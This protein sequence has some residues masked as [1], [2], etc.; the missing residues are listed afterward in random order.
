L[1]K[2]VMSQGAV[3]ITPQESAA[4]AARL[5]ARHNVGSLPVCSQSGQL[6]GVV[7]DRDILLRCVAAE[8]DPS[9]LPVSRIMSRS[10]AFV[11]PEDDVRQ[12][13]HQMA[14]HQVRRL[15]VVEGDHVVGMVSLGDLARCGRCEM[16]VSA[17]L[18]ELSGYLRQP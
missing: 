15:P 5:L 16:E 10:P 3:T 9:L 12:A 17:A 13:A 7:T 6:R 2:E 11:G 1:V 18:T 14:R 8:E 4:L